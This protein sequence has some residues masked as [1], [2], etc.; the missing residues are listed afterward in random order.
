M[1]GTMSN[2]SDSDEHP[3]P[4]TE[5]DQTLEL[6]L[7]PAQFEFTPGVDWPQLLYYETLRSELDERP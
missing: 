2:Q 6:R 1:S 5:L 4:E 7:Y 3:V